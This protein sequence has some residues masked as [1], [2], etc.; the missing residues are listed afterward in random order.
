M[1]GTYGT[2][3]AGTSS[4]YVLYAG[5]GERQAALRPRYAPNAGGYPTEAPGR[6]CQLRLARAR[7]QRRPA[8]ALGLGLGLGLEFGFLGLGLGFLGLGFSGLGLGLG[9]AP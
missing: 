4:Q 9:L 5:P 7:P 2:H 6:A 3:E 8:G 1:R